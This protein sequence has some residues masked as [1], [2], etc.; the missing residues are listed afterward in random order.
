VS[1]ASAVIPALEPRRAPAIS[2]VVP[3]HNEAEHVGPL[4]REIRAVLDDN[5]EP[6]ELIFVNDGSNDDTLSR[7]RALQ[8]TDDRIRV[9]DL[10]GNFGEAAALSA[11]FHAAGGDIIVTLDGDGQN[12]PADIPKLL[13]A[14]LAPGVE[15][16]SGR[17]QDRQEDALLRVWPSRLANYLIARVTGFDSHD[18]GCGLKAYRRSAL[19]RIHLPRGMNRF[20]PAIFAVP[21][22]AFAEVPTQD[23]P[24]R[25]GHSHY[26]I[27]RTIIVI[28]DLLALPFIVHDP[29]RA[30]VTFALATGGAAVVGALLSTTSYAATA[31]CDLAAIVCGLIWWNVRRFN[32]T[33]TEGAYRIRVEEPCPSASD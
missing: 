31:F 2:V 9:L 10:D 29:K 11:G 32:R 30:E 27:S 14:L 33:Q 7:L 18:C 15:V 16:V 3:A 23:R 22:S 25:H 12:D 13:A 5:H 26:G 28:R 24:R 20:L 4:Y 8:A 1:A 21:P 17:R 6:W 19:P